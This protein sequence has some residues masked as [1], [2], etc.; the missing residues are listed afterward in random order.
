MKIV[1]AEPVSKNGTQLLAREKDWQVIEPSQYQLSPE[2]HLRDADAL[3]V[4][5][6]VF[7]DAAM[8]EK[9]PKVRV[10]GRA[11]VG[12]DNIDVEAAT[13]R[14]IVVM[15]T[16]GAN[17]VAV[18]ELAI[19][20]MIS[21]A[22]HLPRADASTRAGKW[23]KKSFQGTELRGKEL[24]ILGLGRIGVEVAKRAKA[25]GM[26]V[27][28]HDPYVSPALARD[29]GLRLCSLDDL[30]ATSDYLSLH[31]GLSPQTHGMI[32][33]EALSKVKKG[34]RIINCARG[35]LVDETA[36]SEALRSGHVAGAALD[37]FVHEP[38][39]NS[40]LLELPNLIATPHIGASTVEAQDAVGVQLAEQ[41]REYLKNGVVQNAVNVPSL[42]EVEYQ[43][44]RPYLDLAR[45]MGSLLAQLMD[46]DLN[47]E[48]IRVGYEG[49]VGEWKTAVL[50]DS[51]V[52]GVLQCGSQEVV[53]I[54]NAATV[55]ATR[56][57]NI[58]E[59][60]APEKAG[61]V[62]ALRLSLK[63]NGTTF[64]ARGTVVHGKFPRLIEL[65]GIDIESPLEGYLVVFSNRDLPG[66][67]GGIGTI[68]GKHGINIA[69]FSLGREANGHPLPAGLQ[70]EQ[71]AR[72]AMA[73][74]QTDSAVPNPVLEEIRGKVSAV[75]GAR[76][77]YL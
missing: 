9:A 2:E 54:V 46:S 70:D 48:E 38:P 6:A 22:R 50:R 77:I 4:R 68:L 74:V 12:V 33:A 26:T 69:R 58:R 31:L 56:G 75:K 5:S 49:H 60:S 57:V 63:G 20:L 36:L 61:H 39:K 13:R 35:E 32:G 27:S 67:I 51:A 40:P 30:Y 65:N 72:R 44:L 16:P 45:R 64:E 15:N 59:D 52:A 19:G 24:G 47:L 66:V 28:A 8:L 71:S 25:L 53:N 34:V 37:V 73:I 1:I 42:T 55:A 11:G 76:P 10:I 62:N 7:V 41:V 21:L 18:A 17:A 14:G 29:L 3:I 23:E 43:Q